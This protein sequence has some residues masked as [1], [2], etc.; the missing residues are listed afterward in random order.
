MDNHPYAAN[1]GVDATA[2]TDFLTLSAA[3]TRGL[4]DAVAAS[5]VVH[6]AKVMLAVIVN[7]SQIRDYPLLGLDVTSEQ[8]Y[9]ST[10]WA[11]VPYTVFVVVRIL[12]DDDEIH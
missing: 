12:P 5:A 11:P 10:E 4:T 8:V 1:I 2:C 7:A 3:I 6:G 9:R